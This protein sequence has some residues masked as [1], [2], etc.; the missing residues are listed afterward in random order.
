MV[1]LPHMTGDSPALSED[2]T[3]AF[4]PSFFPCLFLLPPPRLFSPV[5]SLLHHLTHPSLSLG[6][7]C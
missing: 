3:Y 6:C 7:S 4:I 5:S 1:K 2:M